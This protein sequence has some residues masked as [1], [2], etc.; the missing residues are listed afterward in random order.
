[1][2]G[3]PSSEPR[4]ERPLRALRTTAPGH[5]SL[6]RTAAE[7]P[8]AD[9][10]AIAVAF[11]G[12]CG[13][14]YAIFTG[15][16]PHGHY[17]RIQGH[18]FSGRVEA[19]GPDY[20]GGLRIGTPVTVD[21]V[22]G[23]G[24]CPACTYGAPNAC[25]AIRVLGVQADGALRSRIIVPSRSVHPVGDLPLDLAALTEPIAVALHAVRRTAVTRG[26]RL[27]VFGAGPVGLAV[28][29]VAGDLGARVMT[30]DHHAERARLAA[31]AGAEHTDHGRTPE[32]AAAVQRWC[33][34]D[35]PRV[36]IDATG[37]PT[38]LRAAFGI[39]SP[40]GTIGVVGVSPTDLNVPIVDFTRKELSVL[41]S[42]NS[43]GEFPDAVHLVRRHAPT[44]R[45]WLANRVPLDGAAAALRTPQPRD[46]SGV[47]T[48]IE[49]AAAD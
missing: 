27:V 19:V 1:M 26:D 17:P 13:S 48:L 35:V 49:V 40:A 12:L 36:V 3:V 42:R 33:G 30:V 31:A 46:H 6:E 15:T 20:R 39:V 7:A 11:V 5:A 41:G 8:D 18:E 10:I 25:A 24:R 44:I 32:T 21:P 34:R 22:I 28:T 2:T 16:H 9:Q 38:A 47:K 43:A 37:S 45:G 23:C 29:L 14:D 4:C